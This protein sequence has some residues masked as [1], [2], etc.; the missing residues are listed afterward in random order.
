MHST[1]LSDTSETVTYEPAST[2]RYVQPTYELLS[3]VLIKYSSLTV[4]PL[5]QLTET[6]GCIPL[7]TAVQT[8][9]NFGTRMVSFT[10]CSSNPQEVAA[11]SIVMRL[12]VCVYVCI[13]VYV[14]VLCVYACVYVFVCV[15]VYV[16]VL[17]VCAHMCMCVYV[18]VCVCMRVCMCVCVCVCV[19]Q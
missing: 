1:D 11:V 4:N 2:T 12:C 5:S 8:C 6:E 10:P 17:C 19:F 13:C 14:C 18:C 3:A 15:C 7:T 16:C 9:N